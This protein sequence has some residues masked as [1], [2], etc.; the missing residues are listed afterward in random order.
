MWQKDNRRN[1]SS[2]RNKNN[3]RIRININKRIEVAQ[4]IIEEIMIYRRIRVNINKIIK[5]KGRYLNSKTTSALSKV[6]N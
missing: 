5:V 1:K 3:R 2:I 4:G 6:K